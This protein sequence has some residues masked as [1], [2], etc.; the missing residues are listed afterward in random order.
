MFKKL[1]YVSASLSLALVSGASQ[2]AVD[3]T[4]FDTVKAD[5]GVVGAGLIALAA[6][7]L[8]FKWVKAMFF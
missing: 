6:L 7:V 1:K 8:G 2:A 5:L 3:A 4:V